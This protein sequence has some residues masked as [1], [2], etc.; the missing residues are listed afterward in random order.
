[1]R[2]LIQRVKKASVHVSG[3]KISSIGKGLLLFVGIETND[4]DE[5]IAFLVKKTVNLRIF[6]DENRVMNLSVLDT[7]GEILVVSQFTLLANTKKGNRPS[8]IF[9][10]KPEIS[11]PIYEQFCNSLSDCL[12]KK[13]STGKFG[14]D[15]QINLINDGPVTIWIDSKNRE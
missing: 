4:N 1:M 2:L 6:D 5:D 7:H 8:Y 3:N 12:Q 10:A 9:A 14:A 13:V 15:M 11:I